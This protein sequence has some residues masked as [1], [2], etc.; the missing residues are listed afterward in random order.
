MLK[1]TRVEQAYRCCSGPSACNEREREI[2][3]FCQ[4]KCL[5]KVLACIT[6]VLCVLVGM[7]SD[8]PL[9]L[10]TNTRSPCFGFTS[11]DSV[12]GVGVAY[13]RWVSRQLCSSVGLYFFLLFLLWKMRND[14]EVKRN[15]C[16]SWR[17]GRNLGE[18]DVG[19][20]GYTS[21]SRE[22]RS[23]PSANPT[24]AVPRKVLHP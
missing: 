15:T 1:R 3:F 7:V 10:P 13:L 16:C 8:A 4:N 21:D 14:Q 11:H 19:L 17:F 23:R 20:D 2:V 6:L 5:N 24:S 18:T 12:A 22:S 9:L